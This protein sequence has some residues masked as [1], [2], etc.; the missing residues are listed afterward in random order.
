MNTY[1]IDSQ[2][3]LWW[4]FN[5]K[6]LSKNIKNLI[7]NPDSLIFV[8]LVS[9]WEITL[10]KNS[11]KLKA[12][13]NLKEVLDKDGFQILQI[14]FDHILYLEK[15]EK[16]HNDPFDRLLISQ[17]IIENLTF[18]TSDNM[19]CKYGNKCIKA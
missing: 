5:D 3:L 16:I 8:S 4:L 13:D 11:N 10:K 9:I 6:K 2:I 1:L 7:I 18:I 15:L 19:I 17:S 12:P 14:T